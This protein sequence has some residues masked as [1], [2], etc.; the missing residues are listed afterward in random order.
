M[1]IL[2]HIVCG[3]FERREDG[4]ITTG[5]MGPKTNPAGLVGPKSLVFGGGTT[6]NGRSHL[7][8]LSDFLV[9][10]MSRGDLHPVDCFSYKSSYFN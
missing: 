7:T 3:M 2:V 8:P 4:P 10:R 1:L 9:V 5:I 6:K